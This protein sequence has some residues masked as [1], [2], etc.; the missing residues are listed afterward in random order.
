MTTTGIVTIVLAAIVLALVWMAFSRALW[1]ADESGPQARLFGVYSPILTWL[2]YRRM[3][4]MKQDVGLLEWLR[5]HTGTLAELGV[6]AIWAMWVGRNY[7][8]LRP[9][10]WP[11]GSEMGVQVY[12]HHFWIYLQKCGQCA[13]WNSSINGGV[14][15]FADYFGSK[16]HPIVIVTTLLWGVM[17]GAKVGLVL[18][19]WMSGIA[20]WWLARL[21]KVGWL[22]RVWSALLAV[23]GGHLAGRMATGQFGMVLSAG[24]CALAVVAAMEV[25][26]TGQRLAT[27]RLAVFGALALVS[28]QGYLQLSLIAWAPALL[29]F[30]LDED[31]S[32]R[33]I[34][35]EYALAVGLCL[36]LTGVFL[37]PAIHYWPNFSKPGDLAFG[38]VQPLEYAPLNLVIRDMQFMIT[39][40]LGKRPNPELYYLYIGW[41]P[42]LLSVFSLRAT[43]RSHYAPLLYLA[44]GSVAMFVL[45]GRGLL[46]WTAQYVPALVGFRH[47]PLIAVLGVPPLIGLAAYGL[48]YV[49]TRNWPRMALHISSGTKGKMEFNLAWLLLIPLASGLYTVYESNQAFFETTSI[50]AVYDVIGSL[51]TPGLEW[52]STPFGEHYWVEPALDAGL[53]LTNVVYPAMWGGRDNPPPRLIVNRTEVSVAGWEP[54]GNL[55][56]L[57][58]YRNSGVNYAFVNLGGLVTPCNA[59]GGWGQIEVTCDLAAPGQLTVQENMWTGWKAWVDGK[60]APMLDETWLTV[61]ALAGKHTYTFRYLPWDVPLGLA[62]TLGGVALCIILWYRN[63]LARPAGATL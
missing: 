59:A 54:I 41:V 40:V 55:A 5:T 17:N 43:Q 10:I 39:D 26:M 14:P 63:R 57:F 16:L 36:L 49:W 37:V 50:K 53:K 30:V 33:P 6:I 2:R 31:L 21:L 29:F 38:V 45:A 51:R 4:V 1:R 48:D 52:V 35:R 24:A 11:F 32:L 9:Y 12:T 8:D 47:A 18:S 23:A 61:D 7:L 58:T 13:L 20:Q 46:E 62:L 15:A 27:L 25:G 60:P 3:P 19:L 34:W 28:G 44:T 56:D 42:V 22:G